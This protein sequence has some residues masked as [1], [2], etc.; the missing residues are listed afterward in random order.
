[1]YFLITFHLGQNTGNGMLS[2]SVTLL[3]IELN[4]L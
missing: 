3:P 4:S 2:K 1:M